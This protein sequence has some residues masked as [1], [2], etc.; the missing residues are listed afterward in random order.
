MLEFL[1][2]DVAA[3]T[4]PELILGNANRRFSGVT[5]TMLQVLK[6][7]QDQI[8]VIVLG[9]HHLPKGVTSYRLLP[10]IRRLRQPDMMG[11]TVVFHARRNLEMVQG[12][13]LRSLSTCRI[14]VLFTS[15]AQR[16]HTRFTRFLMRRMDSIISTCSAA[17]SFLAIPPDQLIPHGIDPERYTPDTKRRVP[18]LEGI[19]FAS[20]HIGLFG[21]VRHQKGVDILLRAVIPLLQSNDD[22]DVVIVGQIK[23]G[24]QK[25]VRH[26]MQQAT[27]AGVSKQ[28]HFLG[29]QPFDTLPDLFAAMTIVAALS[30]NEGFGL[31][32]LE[33]MSAGKPVVAS[34]AG[35]WPD[36]IEPDVNGLLVG[37][38]NELETRAAVARLMQD[39]DL[40]AKMGEA[41]RQAVLTRYTITAEASRL[42]AHYRQLASKA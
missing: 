39:S 4:T 14:K 13:L 22:W 36:I 37:I 1:M 24:D 17:A 7:Q 6:A 19:K 30:R 5:S 8:T 31:T 3:S 15:T 2:S 41:A 16:H 42:L 32:V 21:R 33:A 38:D 40:R 18:A 29:E 25:F 34:R 27:E 9:Q 23:D 10:L 28:I 12:I 26:L 20:K 11:K 35:A